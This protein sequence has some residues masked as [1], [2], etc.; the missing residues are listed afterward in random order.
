MAIQNRNAAEYLW[1]LLPRSILIRSR[2]PFWVIGF[3][4][5]FPPLRI[6]PWKPTKVADTL[7]PYPVLHGIQIIQDYMKKGFFS[8]WD[9]NP[10]LSR[11]SE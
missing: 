9:E 5:L 3:D 11:N 7:F 8:C 4:V 1:A 6:A 2:P 10:M